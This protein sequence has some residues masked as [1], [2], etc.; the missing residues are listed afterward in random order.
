MK[1]YVCISGIYSSQEIQEIHTTRH[2]C[3]D[4]FTECYSSTWRDDFLSATDKENFREWLAG[5]LD[6]EVLALDFGSI[7][8]CDLIDDLPKG[9]PEV[10]P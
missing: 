5:T 7:E 2:G 8:E 6:V 3:S 4:W 10:L 9:L 1:V